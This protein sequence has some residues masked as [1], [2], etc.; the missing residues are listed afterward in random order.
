LRK[1]SDEV[2]VALLAQPAGM[3]RWKPPIL[4]LREERIGRRPARR[5]AHEQAPLAP[6]V[7]AAPVDPQREIQVPQQLQAVGA[8]LE[9]LE[10][11][12]DLPLGVQMILVHRRIV[13]GRRDGSV[14]EPFGPGGPTDLLAFAHRPELREPLEFRVLLA[15][16]GQFG[17]ARRILPEE[18]GSQGLQHPALPPHLGRI[19]D[20]CPCRRMH[21]YCI[22][23]AGPRGFS[24]SGALLEFR[25][26]SGVQ[27]EFVPE[28]TA[29]RIVRAGVVGQFPE[30]R[31]QR[32]RSDQMT[33]AVGRP[34]HQGFQICEVPA[35]R[36]DWR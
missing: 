31:Q 10:L 24:G 23:R 9:R 19:I 5:L 15:V 22:V 36:L 26:L 13:V 34:L 25:N 12:V 29:C 3:Q 28:Q 32:Q 1:A 21:E 4:T 7:V 2:G 14:T 17:P 35:P 27:I 6:Y 16:R 8:V 30:R 18:L 33:A 20:Q 11:L